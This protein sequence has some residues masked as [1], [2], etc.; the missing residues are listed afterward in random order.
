MYNQMCQ[1]DALIW[2]L[3]DIGAN[4]IDIDVCKKAFRDF[5]NE[6]ITYTDAQCVVAKY[7]AM[8]DITD[9]QLAQA[10]EMCDSW[11]QGDDYGRYVYLNED[12]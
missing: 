10:D 5:A 2:S 11:S 12:K 6:K 4:V 3:V 8:Y 9:A 1:F 7:R